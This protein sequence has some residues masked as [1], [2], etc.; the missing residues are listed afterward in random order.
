M[1]TEII[2]KILLLEM[3]QVT[4]DLKRSDIEEWDSMT[5]LVLISE[6]EQQFDFTIDD[7]DVANIVTIGDFK[8]ILEKNDIKY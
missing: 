2:A 6:I 1:L 4:D 7:D 5:H 3:D 8:S